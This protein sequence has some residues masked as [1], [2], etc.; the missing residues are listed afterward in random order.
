MNACKSR[1]NLKCNHHYVQCVNSWLFAND[2]T[3]FGSCIFHLKLFYGILSLRFALCS[4]I[5]SVLS[6][7]EVNQAEQKEKLTLR[8]QS[9]SIWKH[10]S[11]WFRGMSTLWKTIFFF[12]SRRFEWQC[13]VIADAWATHFGIS[14]GM[15]ANVAGAVVAHFHSEW[16]L[17]AF[18]CDSINTF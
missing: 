9:E 11:I 5:V 1:H 4:V 13:Y 14:G 2:F 8:V 15:Y 7:S 3:R 16:V 10:L 17:S 12:V 6:R 18:A